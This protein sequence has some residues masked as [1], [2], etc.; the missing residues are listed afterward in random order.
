MRAAPTP[1]ACLGGAD[2]L[3]AALR[4]TAVEEGLGAALADAFAKTADHMRNRRGP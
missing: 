4:D 1:Y 3:R 2:K